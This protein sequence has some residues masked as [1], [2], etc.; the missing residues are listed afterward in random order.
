MPAVFSPSFSTSEASRRSRGGTKV[1]QTES[2]KIQKIVP[3]NI[4]KNV[5]MNRSENVPKNVPKTSKP[6]FVPN[7][8]LQK[9]RTQ[10]SIVNYTSDKNTTRKSKKLKTSNNSEN[11]PKKVP[12]SMVRNKSPK[13]MRSGV[14]DLLGGNDSFL[15]SGSQSTNHR[16]ASVQNIESEKEENG[17]KNKRGKN[18]NKDISSSRDE[19]RGKEGREGEDE[20]EDLFEQYRAS[21]DGLYKNNPTGNFGGQNKLPP[22]QSNSR[23]VMGSDVTYDSELDDYGAEVWG[24]RAVVGTDNER[25]YSNALG[26]VQRQNEDFENSEEATWEE[27][28][29]EGEEEEEVD[30]RGS[31]RNDQYDIGDYPAFGGKN[32][33]YPED[34]KSG[35]KPVPTS[36]PGSSQ[37]SVP[38]PVPTSGPTSGPESGPGS[39]SESVPRFDPRSTSAFGLYGSEERDSVLLELS[40]DDFENRE[41]YG[42]RNNYGQIELDNEEVNNQYEGFFGTV[43]NTDLAITESFTKSMDES[44]DKSVNKLT[45]NSVNDSVNKISNISLNNPLSDKKFLQNKITNS[46][47][48]MNYS[49]SNNNN[50]MNDNDI[51][52]ERNEKLLSM[53]RNFWVQDPL[54]Q[55]Q[56]GLLSDKRKILENMNYSNISIDEKKEENE[57]V[58]KEIEMG[59]GGG[60]G[61]TK[62]DV[63]TND[64]QLCDFQDGVSIPRPISLPRPLPRYN[65]TSQS[66]RDNLQFSLLSARADIYG[67]AGNTV[68]FHTGSLDGMYG[69]LRY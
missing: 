39:G 29:Y 57:H 3:K 48:S 56:L 25:M 27:K 23:S 12:G 58:G 19:K 69:R 60:R 10:Q 66:A 30:E 18:G 13:G 26:L 7:S 36:N 53:E 51:N 68:N 22:G 9:Q 33:N 16:Y 6:I 43:Q 28:G 8:E 2:A 24:V 54:V 64:N 63:Y 49:K 40:G 37:R 55:Q 35:P 17:K 20:E 42:N 31:E 5:P 11:I 38:K 59:K 15:S 50:T 1:E 21:Y 52:R 4:S 61:F 62:N 14:L 41:K 32:L 47:D 65:S 44:V 45:N 34:L 46:N 67:I